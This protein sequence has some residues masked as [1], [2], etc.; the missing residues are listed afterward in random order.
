MKKC[1]TCQKTFDDNL[2]F[3]QSD[4]TPLVAVAED[5]PEE[6]PFK[7]T[8]AKQGDLPI[9]PLEESPKEPEP[10]APPKEPEV[11]PFATMVAGSGLPEITED[12]V[13]EVP[14]AEEIDPLKTMVA[15][16]GTSGKIEIDL[17][18]DIPEDTPA[19]PPD[20]EPVEETTPEAAA[21]SFEK[22]PA[23]P[24]SALPS[25]EEESV[26]AAPPEAE[27]LEVAEPEP[28]RPSAT[29]E[30]VPSEADS[31]AETT[32]PA[33][34]PVSAPPPED[35]TDDDSSG[36]S[37]SPIPSPF[38]ES[39]PPGFNLPENP[40]F[41]EKQEEEKPDDAPIA[42]EEVS[43]PEPE[44]GVVDEAPP[45]IMAGEPSPEM[46]IEASSASVPAETAE[47]SNQTLSFVSLGLGVASVF[48]CPIGILL[49]PAGI[50]TGFIAKGKIKEDP[51]AYGG[52]NYALIGMV[53][54]GLGL[55]L[56]LILI[57]VQIFFSVLGS[58]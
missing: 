1:P 49:G 8:V 28:E 7:T 18:E 25:E 22:K 57:I 4:G 6:N 21:E 40:P 39:L 30:P 31:P 32:A 29:P 13:L 45:A 19:R 33:S 9:P 56:W 50:V 26:S 42:T 46:Q 37:T 17:P 34:E 44:A 14:Q 24:E 38:E 16:G 48:C 51:A 52:G 23:Q 10:E 54:G 27:S 2:K 41:E 5:T 36:G 15:G 43:A 58:V 11:D 55:L 20:E 53:A 47:G 35:T 12:D 3:C